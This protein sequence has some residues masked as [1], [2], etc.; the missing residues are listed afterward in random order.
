[1][2]L[3]WSKYTNCFCFFLL[4]K[5]S[6]AKCTYKKRWE[7]N[8]IYFN[9]QEDNVEFLIP[10]RLFFPPITLAFYETKRY[11]KSVIFNFGFTQYKIKIISGNLTWFSEQK[12]RSY[13]NSWQI[14]I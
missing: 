3:P 12:Q 7:G 5:F 6:Q 1:M 4:Q 8:Y 13:Y 14:N 10:C 2:L 9:Y 11:G